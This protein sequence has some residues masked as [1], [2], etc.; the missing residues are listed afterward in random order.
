MV[1]ELRI[2]IIFDGE[3]GCE[4]EKWKTV[5]DVPEVLYILIWIVFTGIYMYAYIHLSIT[6]T[7]CVCYQT[8]VLSF[9]NSVS[10]KYE[11]LKRQSS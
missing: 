3:E 5:W 8:E 7:I 1:I 10:I 2:L 11:Q 9:K 4:E 6:L